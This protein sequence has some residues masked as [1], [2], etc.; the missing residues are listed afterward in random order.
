MAEFIPVPSFDLVVF[1][2]TGD[3]S[4]R[5][6]FP[7]LLH[8]FLDGQIDAQCRIIGVARQPMERDDF[9]AM[10]G[11]NQAKLNACEAP[12]DPRCGDFL[13]LLDY[14]ALDAAQPASAWESL[15]KALAG[16]EGKTRIFYLATAPSLFAPIAQR[17]GE[18]GLATP[19]SRIVLEKPIGRDLASARE[20]NEGVGAVF[21]EHRTFRIDHYLG[22]E[23]VQNLMVLRFGNTLFEPLWTR[24]AIDHVQI[25]VA[26]E[27]GVEG[28]GDYYDRSGAL[29]DMVQNHILQLLCLTAM[30]TPGSMDADAIRA[31]KLKV[32]SALKPIGPADQ[33]AKT[34]RGQY[35]AGLANGGAVAGYQDEISGRTSRTETFVAI[36]AEVENW[37]W[38]GVP[39]Y[40]RTGKRMAARRSEIVVQ[41]KPTPVS[42]FG[43]A[44]ETAN[45]LVLRLQP[46]EA[47]TLWLNV[48]EPGPGGLRVKAAPLNLSYAAAFTLRYPDAY[49]RLLMDVARGNLSLFMRREEVEAAWRWADALLEAW[50][51]SEAAPLPYPAGTDGPPA[52]AS[53][54][55]RDGRAWWDPS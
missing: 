32:L 5:K 18:T 15:E 54:L 38:A 24:D 51:R 13:E 17:L 39:F 52:A 25:T 45:R 30:E 35:R 19:D 47:V 6:L 3:L 46:D 9:R 14:V 37:R 2:A 28:R 21:D 27:L 29:R 43:G 8:R 10:V 53:L 55:D 20:V 16:G 1:G 42:M 41:F 33:A 50:E 12:D 4:M 7:A 11:E 40:L 49:E 36:K 44:G 22:K 31:E 34:V 48:K 23:T 26:E